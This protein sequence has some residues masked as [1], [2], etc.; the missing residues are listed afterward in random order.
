MILP[1]DLV[2]IPFCAE[3]HSELGARLASRAAD[4]VAASGEPLIIQHLPVGSHR[5]LLE[6][7]D[8]AYHVIDGQTDRFE[9][10]NSGS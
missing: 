6:L 2:S 1:E 5:V 8:P 7:A 4:C 3:I 10:P 9:I